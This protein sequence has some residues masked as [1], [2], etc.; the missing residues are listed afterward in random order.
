MKKT[1]QINLGDLTFN[2]EEDAYTKLS[3]YLA[4]IQVFNTYTITVSF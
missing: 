3:G 2:I 1:L 4:S